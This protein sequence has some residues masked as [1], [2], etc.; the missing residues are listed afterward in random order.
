MQLSVSKSVI[1][2]HFQNALER[3]GQFE[4]VIRT[5][6][7]LRDALQANPPMCGVFKQIAVALFVCVNV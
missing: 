2:R 7:T 4:S 5:V 1:N 6:E 3:V